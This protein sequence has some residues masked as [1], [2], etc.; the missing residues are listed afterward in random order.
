MTPDEAKKAISAG[1]RVTP[2][3]VT[4]AK[5]IILE[6]AKTTTSTEKL[7]DQLLRANGAAVVRP[8][9]VHESVDITAA[10]R[11]TS[12]ALSWRL[13]GGEAIWALVHAGLLLPLTNDLRGDAVN[14]DWTTVAPGGG[15][16]MSGGWT[17]AEARLP[18]PSSVRVAPSHE[19]APD[20][21]LAAPDLYLHSLG[22]PTMHP[23]VAAAFAEAVKCFRLELYTASI[24]MLGKASEGS[25]LELG[26]ALLDAIPISDLPRYSKQKTVLED[27][28][29]G[30]AKKAA[31]VIALYD[32]LELFGA[33]A[34]ASGVRPQELKRV[35][36]WSDAVRDS[37]NTVHFG[38][39]PSVPNTY[40]KIAALLIGAV[41]NVQILYLVRDTVRMHAA[42]QAD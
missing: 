10:I 22:V 4:I 23:D 27:P 28:M 1:I 5:A 40:E 21:F 2:Q 41:P 33:I 17:F 14:I 8:L 36:V 18:I 16:G 42:Q 3:L 11:S 25:W 31:A 19:A 37:R 9:V 26:E 15:G 7:L 35:Y 39:H 34:R 20:L 32:H 38:V 12:E 6:H 29:T 13:A 30:P 24:A